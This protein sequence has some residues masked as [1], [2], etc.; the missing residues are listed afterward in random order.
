MSEPFAAESLGT[1]VECLRWMV[2]HPRRSTQ[3]LVEQ[4]TY[5]P[6]GG[7]RW[8]RTLQLQIPAIAGPTLD[9][10]RAVSVGVFR[11]RR[12]PDMVV[13]DESGSRLN[14]LTR[15]EHGTLLTGVFLAKHL[16]DFSLQ[17]AVA[18]QVEYAP[19][20][21]CYRELVA[22]IYDSL[23]S[24]GN[25]DADT[26]AQR[27]ASIFQ[28]L[29]SLFDPVP[30]HLLERAAAFRANFETILEV[31]HYLCWVRAKPGHLMSIQTQ[32][33]VSDDRQRVGYRDLAPTA[34]VRRS[35]R[36]REWL[37]RSYRAYGLAP[38]NITIPIP[39]H[40]LTGSYYF[41]LEPPPKTDVTFLDWTTGNNFEDD[42]T[43]LDSAYDSVHF[44]YDDRSETERPDHKREIRTYLRCS[45]HGHKQI[46]AGA[47]FNGV[48]VI[49]IAK[50]HFSDVVGGSAQAWLL[51]TPTLL[52][53]Y[54]ADQQRHYYAYAT[55]RQRG[56]LWV[57]LAIS[58]TFL[59]AASFHLA[60]GPAAEGRWDWVGTASA[61]ALLVA[62]AAVAAWYALLGYSFR[63][64]TK[65]GTARA[66][67]RSRAKLG[68]ALDELKATSEMKAK[69]GLLHSPWRVYE[70]VVYMYCR[71]ITLLVILATVGGVLAI[72]EWWPDQ[73]SRQQGTSSSAR[74]THA[75]GTVDITKWPSSD[76][77]GCNVDLRFIPAQEEK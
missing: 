8:V 10:W 25:I 66:L 58:V 56:I 30:P 74:S 33:T 7:R 75:T 22:A 67:K 64:V 6:N 27:L 73:Q 71:V 42:E 34:S 36:F 72:K 41:T 69:L 44:H 76:C 18:Q 49:L 13:F 5:L 50:G 63:A 15:Y 70:R 37:M 21:Q 4:L 24:A 77:N 11:R 62:S 48:F 46:A 19:V 57:Y 68:V 20:H 61:W 9:E 54:L 43:E 32:H 17:T 3:R 38:F 47:V 53:A 51:V 45:T 2:E 52:T 39:S 55:R 28:R 40:G 59:I 29:L 60:Q 35:A 16:R 26:E 65:W 23:T 14:L 12:F 1:H 31:T